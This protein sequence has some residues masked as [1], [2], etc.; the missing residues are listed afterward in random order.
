MG[1]QKRTGREAI[2]EMT[3]RAYESGGQAQAAAMKKKATE[4]AK[5][6]DRNEGR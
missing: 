5:R 2:Q 1:D 3:R 6:R 4:A